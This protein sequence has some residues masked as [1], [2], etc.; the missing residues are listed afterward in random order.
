MLASVMHGMMQVKPDVGI[1]DEWNDAKVKPLLLSVMRGMVQVVWIYVD[2][3]F[4]LLR[5]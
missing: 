3:L 1:S 4:M 5:R 2:N